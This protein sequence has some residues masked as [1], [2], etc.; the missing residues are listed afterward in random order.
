MKYVID[1]TGLTPKQR[2]RV[3]KALRHIKDF[4]PAAPMTYTGFDKVQAALSGN[5]EDMR[6][7]KDAI[8]RAVCSVLNCGRC[9]GRDGRD[10][11][12]TCRNVLLAYLTERCVDA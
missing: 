6:R 11:K 1:I 7:F 2:D 5:P 12:G 3:A 9:P 8:A 10:G 4:A